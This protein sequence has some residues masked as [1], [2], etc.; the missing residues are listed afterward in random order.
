MACISNVQDH[1]KINWK[2]LSRLWCGHSSLR[3]GKPTWHRPQNTYHTLIVLARQCVLIIWCEFDSNCATL[4]NL[5][6]V[7][8]VAAFIPSFSRCAFSV[9]QGQ[10]GLDIAARFI[11]MSCLVSETMINSYTAVCSARHPLPV[12]CLTHCTQ[13]MFFSS[14]P[15]GPQ[16]TFAHVK[17]FSMTTHFVTS[18]TSQSRSSDIVNDC[19]EYAIC[20]A[21]SK[22][23]QQPA[24]MFKPQATHANIITGVKLDKC[25]VKTYQLNQPQSG[26]QCLD[27][28][29]HSMLF[30]PPSLLRCIRLLTS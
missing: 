24:F 21:A 14:L 1:I 12:H 2:R 11:I 22:L 28:I 7:V 19:N 9:V 26:S 16:R 3:I 17:Q 27:I 29:K 30:C 15:V 13:C 25:R 4:F 23:L 20:K 6:I 5:G 10:D 18:L 8:C